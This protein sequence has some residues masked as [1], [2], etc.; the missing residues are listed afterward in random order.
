L[1]EKTQKTWKRK[2]ENST[3]G[4]QKVWWFVKNLRK[5]VRYLRERR[6]GEEECLLEA[7]ESV[8]IEKVRWNRPGAK[9]PEGVGRQNLGRKE[10]AILGWRGGKEGGEAA[11]EKSL[12]RGFQER[13]PKDSC[14]RKGGNLLERSGKARSFCRNEGKHAEDVKEKKG[15]NEAFQKVRPVKGR[16]WKE[17]EGIKKE[18]EER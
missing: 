12:G 14:Q 18:R 7:A 10:R 6:K 2:T 5:N 17:K 4:S 3:E 11:E 8:I 1:K 15:N 9:E 13:T 16:S